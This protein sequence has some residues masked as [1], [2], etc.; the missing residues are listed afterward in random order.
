MAL[1]IWRFILVYVIYVIICLFFAAISYSI[2]KRDIRDRLNQL[3]ALFHL[4]LVFSLIS[5]FIYASISDPSSEYVVEFMHKFSMYLIIVASGFLLLFIVL[6][7]NPESKFALIKYQV[8]ILII[9]NLFGIGAFFIPDGVKVTILSDGTQLYPVW[10]IYFFIYYI[11]ILFPNMI[12]SLII[13]IKIY[14]NFQI[15]ALAKRMK[16]FLLGLCCIYYMGFGVGIT[17]FLNIPLLRT[18]F[19]LTQAVPIIGVILIYYSVG[20][21]LKESKQ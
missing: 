12:I 10:N 16:K 7:Y 19:T 17:N 8:L 4:F 1:T 15:E 13:T 5:N 2:L 14:K 20:T 11:A 3:L 21:S 6:L 18:I 9:Y